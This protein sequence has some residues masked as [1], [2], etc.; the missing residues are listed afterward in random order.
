MIS[1]GRDRRVFEYA[2]WCYGA[3]GDEEDVTEYDL[4]YFFLGEEAEGEEYVITAPS[5]QVY[6]QLFSQ[7][8]S[9]EAI[10]KSSL[11]DCFDEEQMQAINQMWI[12]V[13][14]YNIHDIPV[15]TWMAAGIVISSLLVAGG[16]KIWEKHKS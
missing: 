13:R 1:G 3:D 4:G 14:C 8:P 6:R 9:Q 16:K 10:S 12:N 7:Y 11:M 15:W 5:D 2:D